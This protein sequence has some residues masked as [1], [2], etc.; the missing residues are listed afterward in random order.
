MT[1]RNRLS[2]K[3]LQLPP[4]GSHPVLYARKMMLL[5]SCLQVTAPPVPQVQSQVTGGVDNLMLQAM[6]TARSL[7]NSNDEM[8]GSIEGIECIAMES[9]YHSYTG[10]LRRAWL[11]LRR[12]MLIA[13]TMGL[14]HGVCPPYIGTTADDY[15]PP[16]PD[17]LWFTLIH[18]DRYFSLMNGLPQCS[19]ESSFAAPDKLENC[20]PE[21]NLRRL[22]CAAAGIILKNR[23]NSVCDYDTV[24][25][26]DGLLQKAAACMPPRW[27]LISPFTNTLAKNMEEEENWARLKEHVRHYHLLAQLH[28]PSLLCNADEWKHD[29]SKISAVNASRE[30]LVRCISLSDS[31]YVTY[32]SPAFNRI[33]FFASLTLCLGYLDVSRR[34]HQT[35]YAALF[36]HQRQNDRDMMEQALF[37]MEHMQLLEYDTGSAK[38]KIILRKLLAID[39]DASNGTKYDF[40]VLAED[41]N[42][43]EFV[44][45][46]IEDGRGL[47]ILILSHGT[48]VIESCK[49]AFD[50]GETAPT[51]FPSEHCRNSSLQNV[52]GTALFPSFSPMI[53]DSVNFGLDLNAHEWTL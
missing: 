49:D 22:D 14:H 23:E 41:N 37:N 4:S 18:L 46:G 9:I 30:A 5:A 43:C 16:N 28:W 45:E 38:M 40:R 42:S 35:A 31:R 10:D 12:A 13:Q 1:Q 47:R 8:V 51:T 20:T 21:E 15:H 24:L 52:Q 27:W 2:R 34:D 11:T 19:S 33:A 3:V 7:V 6:E 53:S 17:Q 25:E 29:Y 26:A 36:S 39:A 32:H 48:I 50:Y 44:S